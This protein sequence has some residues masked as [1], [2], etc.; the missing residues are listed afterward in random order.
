MFKKIALLS[1]ALL[2]SACTWVAVTPGA[3]KVTLVKP[4]HVVSCSKLGATKANVLAKVGI[5][6]RSDADVAANLLTIAK[7]TAVDMGGDTVVADTA[8]SAGTQTFSI[9]KCR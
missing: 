2:V 7:N 5:V 1:T 8:M 6:E 9:Y 3:E 4:E